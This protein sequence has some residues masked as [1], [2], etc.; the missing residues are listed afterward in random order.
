MVVNQ[1]SRAT[2]NLWHCAC[3]LEGLRDWNALL[4]ITLELS[5]QSHVGLTLYR[6]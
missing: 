5:Y 4:L 3:Y 1:P 2:K 6:I